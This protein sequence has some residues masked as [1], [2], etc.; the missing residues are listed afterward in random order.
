MLKAYRRGTINISFGNYAV[1]GSDT[2]WLTYCEAGDI[3]H[4][5][6]QSMEILAVTANNALVL[7]DTWPGMSGGAL[8]YRIEIQHEGLVRARKAKVE[9]INAER[10]V[11]CTFDVAAHG[12]L[13][14]ADMMSQDL[15]SKAINLAMVGAPLPTVWRDVN[16]NDMPITE[17]SQLAQIAG[18]MAQQTET[19]YHR[20][21][22]M[23]AA[24][25]AATS[26]EE[27][28]EIAW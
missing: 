25:N 6:D 27:I 24:V 12:R 9:Q 16:N 21:W 26:V 19:V 1:T 5:G 13:W 7:V 10:A 28:N 3:L 18:A 15:L 17:L 2:S 8:P 22:E 23:K 4:V 11:R 14:Q 20:S